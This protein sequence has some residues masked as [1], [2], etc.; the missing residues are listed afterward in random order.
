MKKI[1]SQLILYPLFMIAFIAI[2]SFGLFYGDQHPYLFFGLLVVLAIGIFITI[3]RPTM[4]DAIWLCLAIIIA[5]AAFA[6]SLEH[7]QHSLLVILLFNAPFFA[8]CWNKLLTAI[9]H[10]KLYAEIKEERN[11]RQS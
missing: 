9:L 3:V 6:F 11:S 4:K 8:V 2:I 1:N 7:F 10:S 5:T